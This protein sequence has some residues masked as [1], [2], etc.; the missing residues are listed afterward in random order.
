MLA[1]LDKTRKAAAAKP[2]IRR[3][4][5]PPTTQKAAEARRLVIPPRGRPNNHPAEEDEYSR[6]LAEEMKRRQL[7]K[8]LEEREW[9]SGSPLKSVEKTAAVTVKTDSNPSKERATKK[10]ATVAAAEVPVKKEPVCAEQSVSVPEDRGD[11]GNR[12]FGPHPSE[13]HQPEMSVLQT[14]F[15]KQEDVKPES[16][17]QKGGS[18]LNCYYCQVSHAMFF[19][20]YLAVLYCRVGF[21]K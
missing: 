18:L 9:R 12:E 15:V 8:A 20:M 4:V 16:L 2:E 11:L 17:D 3:L 6:I 7:V 5:V 21:L 10:T 19:I 1:R 14:Q 13:M